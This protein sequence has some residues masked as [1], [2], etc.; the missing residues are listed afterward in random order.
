MGWRI[1]MATNNILAALLNHQYL[2]LKNEEGVPLGFVSWAHLDLEREAKYLRDPH[3][4]TFGDW[5]SGDRLWIMDWAS[6]MGGN[7]TADMFSYLRKEIFPGR[8]ARA[9]R[10][11]PGG[12]VAKIKSY[13]GL[14]ISAKMRLALLK[15]H[16]F[17]IK[18]YMNQDDCKVDFGFMD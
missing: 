10:L 6:P 7:I 17:S 5:N 15:D 16:Y 9:L 11:K 4:L 8:V 1:D 2:L 18:G 3:S 12:K 14:D 13:G